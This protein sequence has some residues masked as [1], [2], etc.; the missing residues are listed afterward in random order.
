LS[1]C[2]RKRHSFAMFLFAITGRYV[3]KQPKPSLAIV[4]CGAVVERY[5]APA[6]NQ[7]DWR[8]ALLQPFGAATAAADV[9][10]YLDKIEAAMI[11]TPNAT[12]EAICVP[13]LQR[14]IQVLLGESR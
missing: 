3:S 10:A 13:L 8:P 2:G 12:H 9:D 6:L 1:G 14:G 7:I 4:G 11:A 5:H